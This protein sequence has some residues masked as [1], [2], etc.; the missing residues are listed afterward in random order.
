VICT[1]QLLH[2]ARPRRHE[3]ARGTRVAAAAHMKK[4]PKK[5][6]LDT[7]ALR[8]LTEVRLAEVGGGFVSAAPTCATCYCGN[9]SIACTQVRC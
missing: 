3:R 7:Q 6:G 2:G 9:N 5:L 8:P 4:T 1:L